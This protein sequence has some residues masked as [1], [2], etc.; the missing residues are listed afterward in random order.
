MINP[1]SQVRRQPAMVAIV[2]KMGMRVANVS[3]GTA[4]PTSWRRRELNGGKDVNTMI[5]KISCVYVVHTSVLAEA[6]S[7]K[8]VTDALELTPPH[9]KVRSEDV[10]TRRQP[11][12]LG[13]AAL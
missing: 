7:R 11:N 4:H 6:S 5:A 8:A 2:R 10:C 9:L 1:G 12:I 13:G 3:D